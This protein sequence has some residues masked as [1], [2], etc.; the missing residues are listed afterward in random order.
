M[1]TSE[2][3]ALIPGKLVHAYLESPDDLKRSA[4]LVQLKEQL[5]L[6]QNITSEALD[7]L[8]EAV[9]DGRS[10]VKYSAGQALTALAKSCAAEKGGATITAFVRQIIATPAE[11]DA[12]SGQDH[13]LPP[14]MGPLLQSLSREPAYAQAA[15]RAAVKMAN[16]TPDPQTV[17]NVMQVIRHVVDACP[18]AM[19]GVL[20]QRI[21]QSAIY[22]DNYNVRRNALG[23]M[24]RMLDLRPDLRF[25]ARD[26]VETYMPPDTRAA[27][28]K[29]VRGS[30]YRMFPSLWLSA[31]YYPMQRLHHFVDAKLEVLKSGNGSRRPTTP[32]A[33]P[34]AKST[35][36]FK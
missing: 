36:Q 21:A 25:A 1:A 17:V 10:L 11:A 30:L 29:A 26:I 19:D 15:L 35:P 5:P 9:R 32:A 27:T 6:Y 8:R 20:V 24:N 28:R 13:S 3:P 4:F 16:E 23:L 33:A 31:P 18:E 7:V 2:K 14:H 12:Q 34:T 22:N